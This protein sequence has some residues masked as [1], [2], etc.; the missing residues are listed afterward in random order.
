MSFRL[1]C[2]DKPVRSNQ[3]S[4]ISLN[5]LR[6]KFYWLLLTGHCLLFTTP[7]R[8]QLFDPQNGIIINTLREISLKHQLMLDEQRLQTSKMVQ[9]LKQFYDSYTLMRQ[10]AEFTQSL[11]RD[12][13]SI[14]NMQLNNSFA[15]SRF[16]LDADR[17]NYWFP[18]TTQSLENATMNTES[19]LHNAGELQR[20]YESFAL[21]TQAEEA[22][23]DAETRRENALI[24]QEAFSKALFEQSLRSQQM[25]KTYD[26]MAVELYRQVTNPKNKFTEAERTQL[27]VESVKMR[28]LSNSHYEKYLKLG[29]DAHTNEL[30]MY[31]QKLDMLRSKVNWKTMQNQVNKTSRVRYGF[32][33]ITPAAN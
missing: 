19:L 21:S 30:N 28:E 24:G 16:I 6:L 15:A 18:S 33:D 22:P 8:A 20:T 10:D 1:I 7:S 2:S 5:Y 32:F 13:Q 23:K 9:Q 4:V 3:C 12:F 25:A 26:S 14:E 17:L 27:L 29:Q 11:Y 31:D